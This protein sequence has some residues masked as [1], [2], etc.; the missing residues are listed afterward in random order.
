MYSIYS[1][2]KLLATFS[3]YIW[4]IFVAYFIHNSLHFLIPYPYIAFPPWWPLICSLYL[5]VYFLFVIFTSFLNF[6]D[7][8]YK[9]YPT[10]FVFLCLAYFTKH[11][12]LW[13]HL[14]YCKW[15]NFILFD[16]WEVFR[17]IYIYHIFFIHSSADGPLGCSNW[18][19]LSL[20]SQWAGLP[21]APQVQALGAVK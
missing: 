4:Y 20:L 9:Q 14:C 12:A 2:Y 13:V 18:S 17:C 16:S 19:A 15:Q 11:N 8:T 5:W 6:L 10:V 3:V 1:Y 21:C 7:S